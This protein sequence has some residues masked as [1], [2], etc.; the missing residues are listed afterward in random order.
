MYEDE[1]RTRRSMIKTEGKFIYKP[2]KEVDT[3]IILDV[4]DLKFLGSDVEVFAWDK[5]ADRPYYFYYSAKRD[6]WLVPDPSDEYGECYMEFTG[7]V[8][9]FEYI[10][11]WINGKESGSD[12][13]SKRS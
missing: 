3:T 11:S 7:E 13:N 1:R 2:N 9:S 12:A 8:I 5:C 10:T 4:L 6:I